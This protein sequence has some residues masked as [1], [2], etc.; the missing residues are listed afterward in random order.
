[1]LPK[2]TFVLLISVA[3]F[4][5]TAQDPKERDYFVSALNPQHKD[6]PKI[7]GWATQ[8]SEEKLNRGLVAMPNKDGK[9]YLGWRLLKSDAPGTAFNVY[10]SVEGGP[11]VRLSQV[12]VT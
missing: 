8:R 10:R 3:A 5:A 7:T 12:A 11:S 9:V 6:K 4:T 1:M 2:S